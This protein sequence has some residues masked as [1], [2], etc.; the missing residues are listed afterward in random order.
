[1]L[2]DR[3]QRSITY[4]RLSVTDR[5]NLR[6]LYCMPEA[7]MNWTPPS[8]LM[9]DDEIVALIERVFLP[10]GVTKIRLTG[11]EPLVRKGLTGLVERIAALPG[12]TDQS[13]TTNGTLLAP[14]ADR[15]A[16]A[17][18]NRLNVSLD[19]LKPDRFA[20][21]TRGGELRRVLDGIERALEA[22]F[23]ALKV[24]VVMIPGV[25]DDEVLDFAEWTLHAP[26]HVRFI[27]MM[28][29][30]DRTFYDARKFLPVEAVMERIRKRYR[31]DAA[32]QAVAGNGPARM[33]QIPGA[34]GTLGFISPMSRTFCDA[35]N[36]IRLTADGQIK[37]CL[38]RP[39]EADLLGLLRGGASDQ[40]MRELVAAS[41]GVKPEHHEWGADLPIYRTMSQIG[42]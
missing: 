13:L 4:L 17:G 5:C 6:C 22:G 12:I 39:Q 28:H 31:L 1:M 24:N 25:N 7:G 21:I 37:A 40:Q 38:M 20:A 14:H 8:S 9:Q 29:V 27:E 26:V 2:I 30:G 42:G 16:R 18:L 19:S 33:L 32:E 36:R 41:L 3:Y 34:K 35:C 23:S 11:G 10:L 15:L